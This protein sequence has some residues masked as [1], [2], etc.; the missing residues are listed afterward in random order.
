[1]GKDHPVFGIELRWPVAWRNA[2][3][4]N[5]TADFPSMEA[6]AALYVEAI[7]AHAGPGPCV[8]AGLSYAGMIAFE[9]AHQ[10]IGLG[11]RVELVILI[12]S[13]ARPPNPYKLAWQVWRQAWKQSPDRLQILWHSTSWVLGKAMSRLRGFFHSPEPDPDTLTGVLDENGVPMPWELFDRLYSQIDRNY[14][15]GSVDSRGILLRTAEIEGKLAIAPDETFGW[16][17]LFARGLEVIPLEGDHSAIFG[18]QIPAIGREIS[19]VLKRHT[20][21]AND[22]AAR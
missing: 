13:Q 8:V 17:D 3:A 19:R 11:H 14:R 22:Q 1:M 20:P 12:D 21:D 6:M 7:R 10:L 2:I 16:G 15:L 5:R 18:E 9:T 4:E